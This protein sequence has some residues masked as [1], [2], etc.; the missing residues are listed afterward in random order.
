MDPQEITPEFAESLAGGLW[1]IAS[2]LDDAEGI[3]R[4]IAGGL[5]QAFGLDFTTLRLIYFTPTFEAD[6]PRW[7]SALGQATGFSDGP[8]GTAVGKT[9]GWCTDGRF[10][11]AI[12]IREGFLAAAGGMNKV[13]LG[14]IA[15]ELGH[16]HDYANRFRLKGLPSRLDEEAFAQGRIARADLLL[17]WSWSEYFADRCGG[18][19][20]DDPFVLETARSCVPL[21]LEGR[22]S[23]GAAFFR[24]LSGSGLWAALSGTH[25]TAAG[26]WLL[27]AARVAA[28]A[29]TRPQVWPTL[30]EIIP[31]KDLRVFIGRMSA[32]FEPMFGAGDDARAQLESPA[33]R[34]LVQAAARLTAGQ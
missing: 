10:H 30:V 26:V 25:V 12:L 34:E 29:V 17:D 11:A 16:V 8:N 28:C 5:E 15:H 18:V 1:G 3:V 2:R 20:Y 22:R 27:H 6:V 32:V 9:F 24:M 23:V 33:C 7:Q 21:L 14:L 31:D 19:M 13:A 4:G